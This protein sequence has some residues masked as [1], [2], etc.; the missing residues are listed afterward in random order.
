VKVAVRILSGEKAFW[1]EFD[2]YFN[3]DWIVMEP[4]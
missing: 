1:E 2:I 3:E 4:F